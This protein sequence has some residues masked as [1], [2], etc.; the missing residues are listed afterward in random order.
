[1]EHLKQAHGIDLILNIDENFDLA[2]DV[3][4]KL[5]RLKSKFDFSKQ[6][7]VEEYRAEKGLI[8]SENKIFFDTWSDIYAKVLKLI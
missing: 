4:E 5:I 2:K 8:L 6:K 1:M 7:Q 3:Q